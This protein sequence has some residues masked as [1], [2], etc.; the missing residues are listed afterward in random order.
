MDMTQILRKTIKKG[1]EVFIADTA[2]VIG[3]VSLGNNVSVWYGVSMRGDADQITVGDR[4]N[5]QDNA[6]IH[7]DPGIPCTIANDC[8]IGHAAIV[9]GATLQQH[10]LVGMHATVLNH[11]HI[12]EFSIIAA[13]AL[14]KEGE[15]IPPFSLVVGVPGKVIR[16]ITEADQ[17]KI[18]ANAEAYV[19]LSK[20]YL[21]VFG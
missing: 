9:H 20:H 21:S 15:I 14:V 8:I 17:Q 3:M 12:G 4:T 18:I 6:V 10:V 11:A 7:A 2:R 19:R 13:G 16:K 5:I 1:N